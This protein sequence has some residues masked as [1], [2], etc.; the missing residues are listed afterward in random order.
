MI[1]E[2]ADFDSGATLHETMK[3]LLPQIRY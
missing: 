2:A 1:E 3:M